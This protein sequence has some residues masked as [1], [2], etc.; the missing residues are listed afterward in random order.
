M[1]TR[2]PN[3]HAFQWL[4]T[5]HRPIALCDQDG[6]AM[7]DLINQTTELIL[8]R[9]YVGYLHMDILAIL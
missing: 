9:S 8:R 2:H 3:S 1:K 6:L 4:Q 7:L 5:R